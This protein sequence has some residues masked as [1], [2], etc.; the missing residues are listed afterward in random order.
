MGGVELSWAGL[1]VRMMVVVV[2]VWPLV[3]VVSSGGGGSG[4]GVGV[5]G[6]GE[7]GEAGGRRWEVVDPNLEVGWIRP[8]LTDLD[9]R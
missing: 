4:N 5:S 2:T 9:N 3:V 7:E 1:E 6:G 8:I